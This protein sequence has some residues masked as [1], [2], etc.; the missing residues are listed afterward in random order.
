MNS[1][2][3]KVVYALLF[4]VG[5]AQMQYAVAVEFDQVCESVGKGLVQVLSFAR[6]TTCSAG[7]SVKNGVVAAATGVKDGTVAVGRA[8]KTSV[9]TLVGGACLLAVPI[10]VGGKHFILKDILHYHESYKADVLEAIKDHQF[11][12]PE[13]Y[14]YN[15]YGR[16]VQAAEDQGS[17]NTPV[18]DKAAANK[19]IEEMQHANN[20]FYKDLHE[21]SIK[22]DRQCAATRNMAQIGDIALFLAVPLSVVG[23]IIIYKMWFEKEAEVEKTVKNS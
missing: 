9:G 11:E 7:G 20:Q 19:V 18:D 15:K 12:K 2:S 21:L 6:D 8:I 13:S 14:K 17:E 10:V 1:S 3:K 16:R 22:L 5:A 4:S 23:S